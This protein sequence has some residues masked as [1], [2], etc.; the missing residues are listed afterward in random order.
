MDKNNIHQIFHEMKE[1]MVRYPYD[2]ER[3]IHHA[4]FLKMHELLRWNNNYVILDH[5]SFIALYFI[6]F[7][8]Y[9]K[10][11]KVVV[12]NDGTKV[13][14][15]FHYYFANESIDYVK[16]N[17]VQLEDLLLHM[18]ENSGQLDDGRIYLSL[19][20]RYLL[21][22]IIECYLMGRERVIIGTNVDLRKFYDLT[23]SW[24]QSQDAERPAGIPRRM[25]DVDELKNEWKL[26]PKPE[27]GKTH[28]E[29][30]QLLTPHSENNLSSKHTMVQLM[31]IACPET[32][33]I[34][35]EYDHLCAIQKAVEESGSINARHFIKLV[36]FL[37]LVQL[38]V[39]YHIDL[40][41]KKYKLDEAKVNIDSL[42]HTLYDMFQT[43][44]L[45]DSTEEE[46]VL[47]LSSTTKENISFLLKKLFE[48]GM[49]HQEIMEYN[50]DVYAN[51]YFSC[52]KK[53]N[54]NNGNFTLFEFIHKLSRVKKELD[55]HR[56]DT[57]LS[58]ADLMQNRTP[59]STSVRSLGLIFNHLIAAKTA[60]E[61]K[62]RIPL[63]TYRSLITFLVLV[64]LNLPYHFTVNKST[65]YKLNLNKVQMQIA[66]LCNILTDMSETVRLDGDNP[67]EVVLDLSKETKATILSLLEQTLNNDGQM[68][69]QLHCSQDFDYYA[70]LYVNCCKK[71]NAPAKLFNFLNELS[72]LKKNHD[73]AS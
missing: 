6:L 68:V 37:I 66:P 73:N 51:I 57:D 3:Y 47:N 29:L 53:V 9:D 41:G 30:I 36:E 15:W 70:S 24:L 11:I 17:L 32:I 1:G 45:S 52:C 48:G 34:G 4:F 27:L 12:T 31:K 20:Q 2:K 62:G 58:K 43:V 72:N 28:N 60:T 64:E 35:F 18:V 49:S 21:L 65:V 33:S 19:K 54:V 25:L 40:K 26:L 23:F 71:V 39:P 7:S 16:T 38:N 10:R 22:Y 67:N 50:F 59:Y 56:D 13:P 42:Y 5:A 44:T 61:E 55:N 8:Y 69:H 46:V 14:D 63:D